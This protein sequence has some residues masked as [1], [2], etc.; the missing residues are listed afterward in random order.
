MCV[1]VCLTSS[2]PKY[3]SFW[4]CAQRVIKVTNEFDG[5]K[6]FCIGKHGQFIRERS[7]IYVTD[8]NALKFWCD[9]NLEQN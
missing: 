2:D 5:L 3:R 8:N 4:S 1:C 7:S 9:L 6:L